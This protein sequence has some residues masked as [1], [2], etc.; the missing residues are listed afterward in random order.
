[1]Q[2]LR[3][4]LETGVRVGILA[5]NVFL[6]IGVAVDGAESICQTNAV[7][8]RCDHGDPR[9]RE[10]R[11]SVIRCERRQHDRLRRADI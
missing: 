8:A 2:A 3:Y 6:C 4:S 9:A 10:L 1:M 7:A 11:S 5:C